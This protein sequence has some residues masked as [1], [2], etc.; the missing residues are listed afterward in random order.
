[1]QHYEVFLVESYQWLNREAIRKLC[2]ELFQYF[3]LQM[4]DSAHMK[5]LNREM[6]TLIC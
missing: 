3:L 1:M 2:I 6:H 4:K 5:D